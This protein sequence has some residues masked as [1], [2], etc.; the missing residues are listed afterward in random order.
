MNVPNNK[1]KK[2]NMFEIFYRALNV[3]TKDIADT[4]I[5]RDFISL[6][7]GSSFKNLKQ[8]Y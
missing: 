2:R 3:N 4:I 1:I 5:G 6:L 8:D 7:M